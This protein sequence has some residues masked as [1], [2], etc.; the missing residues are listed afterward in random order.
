MKSIPSVIAAF[1]LFIVPNA[2]ALENVSLG[3]AIYTGK[4]NG[5]EARLGPAAKQVSRFPCHRCHGR[6]GLGGK[7][8][9][10]PPIAWPQLSWRTVS[11]PAYDQAAFERAVTAGIT[12]AER[13]ISRI[14]PRYDLDQE[15]LEALSAYLKAVPDWQRRGVDARTVSV[16]VPID[17]DSPK[18]GRRYARRL[19]QSLDRLQG[20]SGIYGR[21]VRV[22]A[23]EGNPQTIFSRA[24][25]EVVAVIGLPVLD[26][27]EP[28]DLVGRG[29]PVLF[30]LGLF[31]GNEDDSIMRG[32]TPSR[33]DIFEAL[34]KE[35]AKQR[36][37]T[38]AIVHGRDDKEGAL[39]LKQTLRLALN[40]Q[41]TEITLYNAVESSNWTHRPSDLILWGTT[42]PQNMSVPVETR[43]W[44]SE[45]H[46]RSLETKA[47]AGQITLVL[48]APE[49]VDRALATHTDMIETHA[50]LAAAT[51]VEVLKTVGRLVTRARLVQAFN[52]TPLDHLGLDY[53]KVPLS[54]TRDVRFL[55]V[56]LP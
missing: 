11:R 32:F 38:V 31:N 53:S 28:S 36:S 46:L 26:H 30:P 29:I 43:L 16:G 21:T 15:P 45:Q 19:Q 12:S 47:P 6:D 41:D 1:S 55:P 52:E 9:D 40:E 18:P 14:M 34:G 42:W 37:S 13:N 51:L 50:D 20:Q 35:I 48:G 10:V 22:A 49:L 5:L 23:L 3:H 2:Q 44:L 17:A 39:I 8:G 33:S 7:E 27:I 24:E 25:A 56:N 54:G 4:I